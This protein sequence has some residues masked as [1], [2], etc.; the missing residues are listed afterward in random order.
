MT[1][2][3]HVQNAKSINEVAQQFSTSVDTLRFYDRAGLFPHLQRDEHGYR[4]F[5]PIDLQDLQT[6]ICFRQTGIGVSEIAV[7]MQ[8]IDRDSTEQVQHKLAVLGEQRQ[9]LWQQ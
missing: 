2:N 6:I 1:E 5:M 8:E 7:I 3:N 9:K 4:K